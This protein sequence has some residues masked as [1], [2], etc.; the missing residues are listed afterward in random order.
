ML[1]YSMLKFQYFLQVT[2]FF[3]ARGS[4]VLTPQRLF[5]FITDPTIEKESVAN[6]IL[7]NERLEKLEDNQ[8]LFL[9]VYIPHKLDNIVHFERDHKMEKEGLEP[10]NPYQKLVAKV[11]SKEGRGNF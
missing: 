10:N 6:K 1:A 4:P 7:D 9:H 2:K 8:Y 3:N 5:E 11:V